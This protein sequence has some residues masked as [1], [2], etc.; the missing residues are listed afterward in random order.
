MEAL[1]SVTN[2]VPTGSFLVKNADSLQQSFDL[3]C[4]NLHDTNL[5]TVLSSVKFVANFE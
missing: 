1:F 5:E 4:Y 2:T 3:W